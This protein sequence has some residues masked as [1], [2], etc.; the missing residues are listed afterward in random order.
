M[1]SPNIA[2]DRLAVLELATQALFLAVITEG[3]ESIHEQ[4]AI[5]QRSGN[6]VACLK[7]H[8]GMFHFKVMTR[9]Q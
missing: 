3:G 9:L 7:M 1:Q 4:Q 2:I 5:V 8:I 6:S